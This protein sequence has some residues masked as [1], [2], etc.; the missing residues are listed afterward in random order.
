MLIT[1]QLNCIFHWVGTSRIGNKI[2]RMSY[3]VIIIQLFCTQ[4]I[5]TL[6]IMSIKTYSDWEVRKKLQQAVNKIK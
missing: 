1:N 5:Y 4:F 2:I 6:F 3:E